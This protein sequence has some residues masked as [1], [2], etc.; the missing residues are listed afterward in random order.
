MANTQNINKKIHQKEV[1]ENFKRKIA[2]YQNSIFIGF[3][4]LLL[5]S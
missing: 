1:V 5:F 3:M 2:K 4:G